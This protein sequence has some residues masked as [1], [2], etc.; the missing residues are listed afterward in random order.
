MARLC[1]AAV[2]VLQPAV[3]SPPPEVG[4]ALNSKQ[5]PGA[6]SSGCEVPCRPVDLVNLFASF[7]EK[8]EPGWK[9]YAACG[10]PNTGATL[11]SHLLLPEVSAS[12]PHLRRTAYFVK[13][14]TQ[15]LA[16][17]CMPLRASRR[18]QCCMASCFSMS[19]CRCRCAACCFMHARGWPA[20][21]AHACNKHAAQ[22]G[23][24]PACGLLASPLL[25]E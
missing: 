18:S 10:E 7:A 8:E 12:K 11:C 4:Q 6:V 9:Q 20:V 17:E 19:L 25:Q 13:V 2:C 16:C 23:A 14:L 1:A 5:M 3:K 15:A 21:A 22:A 24:D